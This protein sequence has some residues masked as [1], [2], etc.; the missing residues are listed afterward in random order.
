MI[1][2][3]NKDISITRQCELVGLN[4]S[5]YY[6]SASS[7]NS[8]NQTIMSRIEEIYTK[9]PYYGSRRI[10]VELRKYGLIVNRKRVS[11]LMNLM[12]IQGVAPG[13]S[14]SKPHPKSR[15][16]PYL[17]KD[18]RLER[19]NQAWSSDITYIPTV[20][21]FMYLVAIIDNYSRSILSY[22]LSNTM[23]TD[24][25]VRALKKALLKYGTPEIF[26]TD[27]GSQFTSDEFTGI[28]HENGIKISMDGKGRAL[29]NILMERF[30][31]NLK[32]EDIYLREYPDVLSLH[33]GIG[34]YI[35]YYNRERP[36]Q[37]LG[38]VPPAAKYLGIQPAAVSPMGD[39][40]GEVALVSSGDSWGA[41]LL[42]TALT[43]ENQKQEKISDFKIC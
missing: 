30:W 7:E 39:F 33:V 6:K 19:A 28:L 16:Y 4:R 35:N 40:N 32:Y 37:S 26:N 21:G 5:S 11:R 18:I 41:Q 15:K 29:D 24:F 2:P 10:V 38:Y 1:T 12:G 42:G 8:Q 13:P 22:E 17:L 23:D 27:Q 14:T 34:R 43:R 9:H 3:E 25:C 20:K 36:H 31:R